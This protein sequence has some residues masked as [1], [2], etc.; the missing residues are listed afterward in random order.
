MK[1]VFEKRQPTVKS[2]ARAG[3]VDGLIK[4]AGHAEL[5]AGPEGATFDVG[6]RVREEA[7]LALRDLALD[8]AGEAFATA[9]AD[10]SDRV[11]C[12]AIVAL[13]ERG[14]ADLLADAIP[15]LPAEAGE[16]RSLA[17]RALF[18]LHSAGSSSRLADALVHRHDLLPLSDEDEALVPA[19][20]GAEQRPEALTEVV[21]VLVS[22]LTHQSDIVA[23]RAEGLLVRLGTAGTDALL[24]E[25]ADGAAPHR[26]ATVLGDIRDPRALQP[27]VEAL[28]HPDPRVRSQSC[29]ALG[30]LRDPAAIEPLVNAT[31][32]PEH[33]VRV[34]ASTAL[35]GMGTAAIAA[36]VAALLRPMLSEALGAQNVPRRRSNAGA[37]SARD[38]LAGRKRATATEPGSSEANGATRPASASDDAG[39]V[40]P[41]RRA[42]PRG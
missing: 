41:R 10:S 5:A 36:S 20:L 26:A 31:G 24:E 13:Y 8:R 15:G 21:Q 18:E 6:A 16:S 40:E 28:S 4:A 34:V 11:R 29:F 19:L 3:D 25:L 9:L 30:E 38:Q 27:L 12:A 22:A 42:Q 23:E 14:D 35:D 32:D 7:L 2:L 37:G 17:E 1:R 33:E 39:S